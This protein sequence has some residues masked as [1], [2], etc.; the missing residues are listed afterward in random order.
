MNRWRAITGRRPGVTSGGFTTARIIDRSGVGEQSNIA[1]PEFWAM[2]N[3][4]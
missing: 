2:V 3:K 1:L 4:D